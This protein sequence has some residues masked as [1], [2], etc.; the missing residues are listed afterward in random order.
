MYNNQL[1]YKFHG[2]I[3]NPPGSDPMPSLLWENRRVPTTSS[4]AD[5]EISDY[6]GQQ[7]ITDNANALSYWQQQQLNFPTLSKLAKQYLTV[8][9]SSG[10]VERL[11]SV[12]GKIFHPDRCSL[13]D[14][15]F[16]TLMFI[17]MNSK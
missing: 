10:P 14:H 17:R 9:A 12:A 4:S 11:F 1:N 8:P 13:K 7:C 15:I 5:S 16:E 6:F 3:W 2:M